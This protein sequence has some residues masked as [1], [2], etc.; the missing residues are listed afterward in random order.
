MRTPD[1]LRM[2]IIIHIS[3]AY[4]M[5]TNPV[6]VVCLMVDRADHWRYTIIMHLTSVYTGTLSVVD[7]EHAG[8]RLR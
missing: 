7:S 1:I 5:Q 3:H 2:Y 8:S 6:V 4:I